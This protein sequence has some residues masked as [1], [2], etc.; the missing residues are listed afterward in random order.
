MREVGRIFQTIS[1]IFRTLV[2]GVAQNG[3]LITKIENR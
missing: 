3:E 1:F 2:L